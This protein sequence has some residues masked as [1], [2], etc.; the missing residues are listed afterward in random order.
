MQQDFPVTL[1]QQEPLDLLV[2]QD[3]LALLAELVRRVQR[4]MLEHWVLLEIKGLEELRELADYQE[5]QVELVHQEL[6]ETLVH[7]DS[8]VPLVL[9]GHRESREV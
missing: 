1:V 7:R 8:K 9:L 3:L 6:Q 2:L 5:R 4:V